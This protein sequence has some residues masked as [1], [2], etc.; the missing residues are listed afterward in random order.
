MHTRP[1]IH[2][3]IGTVIFGALF[4]YLIVSFVMFLTRSQVD[5]YQVV[6]GP[7]TGNDTCTAMILRNED[8]I[9]ASSDG[10]VNYFM[11]NNTKATKG[12]LVCGIT[13]EVIPV[14]SKPLD[15]TETKDLRKIA[16]DSSKGV[17]PNHLDEVYDMQYDLLG[18]LWDVSD[19]SSQSSS[20]YV[21]SKDGIVS[22]S[23]DDYC[24][25]NERE[26]NTD[27]FKTSNFSIPKLVNQEHVENGDPLYRIVNSEEWY[28]YFPITDRQ[29]IR[30]ASEGRIRVKF[31]KDGNTE[32]GSLS[33]FYVGDQRYGKITFYSGMIRYVDDRFADVELVTNTQVGLKIPVSA[34]VTKEFYLIP[35][36]L[37]VEGGEDRNPGFYRQVTDKDGNVSTEFVEC[38]LY[39]SVYLNETV[40]TVY[41]VDKSNFSEG[42]ILVNE[43]EHIRYT[44]KE[45]GTLNG[46]YSINKGYA[47]FRKIVVLDQNDEYAIVET[48]TGYGI[49]LYDYIVRDASTVKEESI[50]YSR[51]SNVKE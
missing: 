18:V 16:Y 9:R 41:Y 31:L 2:L 27:L 12:K 30:L 26:F 11:A 29:T 37:L 40:G 4:I 6:Y 43:Y 5:A 34:I 44:I 15:S 7:L 51:H 48:N 10:Y 32:T 50:L 17:D 23:A 25:M 42:D 22:F 38:T 14:Q 24:Y 46:V 21:V 36:S 35:E 33:F 39:S 49:T 45:T 28:I 8:V 19:I 20:Y 13:D 47:L 1:R 3:N